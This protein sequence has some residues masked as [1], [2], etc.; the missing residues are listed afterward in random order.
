[1]LARD[2]EIKPFSIQTFGNPL[3]DNFTVKS[4]HPP[5]DFGF[6]SSMKTTPK[7]NCVLFVKNKV[8]EISWRLGTKWLFLRASIIGAN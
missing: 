2:G 4:T 5:V 7:I 3:S 1:M 6:E 8:A